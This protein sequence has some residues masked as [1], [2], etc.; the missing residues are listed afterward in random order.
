MSSSAGSW[1]WSHKEGFVS[2][3]EG[4]ELS[5]VWNGRPTEAES[6]EKENVRVCTKEV[7]LRRSEQNSDRS[8]LRIH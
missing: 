8:L 2:G 5:L 7:D 3:L 4:G 1:D 6:S